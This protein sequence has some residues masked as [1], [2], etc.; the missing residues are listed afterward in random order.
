[1]AV[2]LVESKRDLIAYLLNYVVSPE[3]YETILSK[4][5]KVDTT[6]VA[7]SGRKVALKK[8]LA[9]LMIPSETVWV[10]AQNLNELYISV[11]RA[12]TRLYGGAYTA[13]TL[14]EMVPYYSKKLME[15]RVQLGDKRGSRPSLLS[16]NRSRA[17]SSA[18]MILAMYR[19][20]Y[21]FTMS[22][23]TGVMSKEARQFRAKHRRVT[24]T[25][26]SQYF[27]PFTSGLLSGLFLKW[28]PTTKRRSDIAFFSATVAA[29]QLFNFVT[30]NKQFA[31]VR[32]QAGPWILFPI[33]L[34][35]L[36]YT[37]TYNPECCPEGFKT[38]MLKLGAGYIPQRPSHY[39]ANLTWPDT[40]ES[41]NSLRAIATKNY[42]PFNSP[43]LY[44]DSYT[45][46]SDFQ[47]ID[48]IVSQA[49]P[50]IKNLSCALLHPDESSC[51]REFA[52]NSLWQFGS[53]AK[54]IGAIYGVLALLSVK[55]MKASLRENVAQTLI[56]F[57]RTNTFVTM[58][59]TSLWGGLCASQALLSSKQLPFYRTRIIGF[60]AGLWAYLDRTNGA[61]KFLPVARMGFESYWRTLIKTKRVL[62]VPHG[63]VFVFASS[64]AILMTIYDRAPQAIENKDY[65]RALELLSGSKPC[66]PPLSA[67]QTPLIE[68]RP[69][70][71]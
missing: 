49:H 52:K 27:A 28:L 64:L 48:P 26:R 22:L 15:K 53:S 66:E 35:Q 57:L 16:R 34:A 5:A 38:L 18:A 13:L 7:G 69:S 67:P 70:L 61:A 60:V 8:H 24:R 30:M 3:E 44:P 43:I 23:H 10:Q 9:G 45:L 1:M 14:A 55:K 36:L 6:K 46:P 65:K 32:Q 33:S 59:I 11:F 20:L 71:P 12:S 4:L 41:L 63:D 68:K 47:T 17:S 40:T 54:I 31:F 25:F 56:A 42:P 2:N 39:P 50:A 62:T 29:E 51:V 21:V 37:F 58:T 19:L